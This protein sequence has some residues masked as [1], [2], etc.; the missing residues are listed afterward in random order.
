MNIEKI[1]YTGNETC[2]VIYSN[3]EE[4]L[5]NILGYSRF[6]IGDNIKLSSIEFKDGNIYIWDIDY[7]EEDLCPPHI[8]PSPYE[9]ER[10]SEECE[11]LV[12]REN[13]YAE[14]I[15][16]HRFSI[17]TK[18]VHKKE[19]TLN[20]YLTAEEALELIMYITQNSKY[21]T[22]INTDKDDILITYLDDYIE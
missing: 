6:K 2:K 18:Y 5:Y 20:D 8:D 14:H 13:E 4:V 17:Y 12:N 16:E 22:L 1:I 3:G 10:Q 11:D 7:I 21:K 19:C 9:A 15:K